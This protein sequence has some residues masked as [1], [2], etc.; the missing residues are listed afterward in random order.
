[1]NFYFYS[2]KIKGAGELGELS[3]MFSDLSDILCS[4]AS[5]SAQSELVFCKSAPFIH[6]DM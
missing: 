6:F 1:M 5:H 4:G 2:Q 3:L